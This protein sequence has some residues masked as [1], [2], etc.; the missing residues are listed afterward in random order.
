VSKASKSLRREAKRLR[1][2]FAPRG[3]V[4]DRRPAAVRED[5]GAAHRLVKLIRHPGE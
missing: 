5:R 3:G 1:A 4:S 2:R